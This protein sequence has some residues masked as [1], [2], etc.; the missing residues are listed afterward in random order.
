MMQHDS[1]SEQKRHRA[2]AL[3]DAV[4]YSRTLLF[5]QGFGVRQP[6]AA[7]R[8]TAKDKSPKVS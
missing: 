2:A 8:V 4:A 6:Y 1:Q 7:S 3:Q 5:P